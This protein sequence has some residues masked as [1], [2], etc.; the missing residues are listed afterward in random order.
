MTIKTV[1]RF[2][3]EYTVKECNSITARVVELRWGPECEDA[4]VD[5]PHGLVPPR[6]IGKKVRITIEVVE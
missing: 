4:Y 1:D 2:V 6:Y 5:V 3:R